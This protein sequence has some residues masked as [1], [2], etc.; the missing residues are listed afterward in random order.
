MRRAATFHVMTFNVLE[1]GAD[2]SWAGRGFFRSGGDMGTSADIFVEVKFSDC[3][4]RH[5]RS[6]LCG[7]VRSQ[8]APPAAGNAFGDR[9]SQTTYQQYNVLSPGVRHFQGTLVGLRPYC[10]ADHFILDIKVTCYAPY[11]TSGTL[12]SVSCLNLSPNSSNLLR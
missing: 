1:G 12:R 3:D 8:G 6:P 11:P 7:L 2:S 10:M 9:E 4:D 5:S